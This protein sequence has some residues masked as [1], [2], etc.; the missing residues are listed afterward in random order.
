TSLGEG[1]NVT[2]ANLTTTASTIK[3]QAYFGV[4]TANLR[5]GSGSSVLF[6]FAT[7]PDSQI[8]S[9]FASTDLA[10]GFESLN[11]TS[12]GQ[13]D[14]ALSFTVTDGDSATLN[15][16]DGTETI[17]NIANVPT[18]NLTAYN[19]TES[20]NQRT[21][22]YQVGLFEDTAAPAAIGDVAVGVPVVT[23]RINFLN[24]SNGSVADYELIIGITPSGGSAATDDVY[25]FLDIN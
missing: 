21:H 25:L 24:A 2:N 13:Y 7:V 18:A 10:F 9:V 5:V 8:K 14:S 20:S 4:V 22:M 3:W 17:G 12:P 15:F 23:S 19:A 1:G 6:S 16:D 11:A